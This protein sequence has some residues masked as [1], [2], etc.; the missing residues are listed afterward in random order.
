MNYRDLTANFL[1]NREKRR[2][3]AWAGLC[4]FLLAS[5][6]KPCALKQRLFLLLQVVSTSPHN[7]HR[8]MIRA[9]YRSM[10]VRYCNINLN[11]ILQ[12]LIMLKCLNWFNVSKEHWGSLLTKEYERKGL[13]NGSDT[14]K[15][16]QSSM[17]LQRDIKQ[18]TV[19]VFHC[20]SV[21]HNLSCFYLKAYK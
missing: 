5:W 10:T 12:L 2:G 11:N 9:K 7:S 18:L 20:C 15:G 1:F 4:V 16:C 19:I 17:R 13:T 3:S 21:I 8:K 14:H 6:R